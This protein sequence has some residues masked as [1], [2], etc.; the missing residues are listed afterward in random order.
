MD[1]DDMDITLLYS[2]TLEISQ[3]RSKIQKMF[4]LF[5]LSIERESKR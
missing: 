2:L 3:I 4:I 1:F 5:V